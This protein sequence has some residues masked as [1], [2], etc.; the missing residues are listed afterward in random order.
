MSRTTDDGLAEEID[1][2][3]NDA[4]ARHVALAFYDYATGRDFALRGDRWFHAASTIKVP[5]LFGVFSLVDRGELPLDS[6]VHVR[7]RF[8]SVANGTSFRIERGRDGG[9]DLHDHIGK[10]MR[11]HDLARQMIVTSSNLATNLLVD[12]V[13]LE[14]LQATIERWIP[15][16]VELHRGVE[17]EAA[18]DAGISNRVTAAGLVAVLRLIQEE[19]P[20]KEASERMLE[21]L[22]AQEFRGG[23]P[24]GLPDDA[25]VANKT[26]EI[27]TVAHDVGLVYLPARE[28]YALAILT[29]WDAN[30][31]GGRR[32]VLSS[33]SRL[34]Y[35][36]LV[37]TD[38]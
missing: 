10:T 18:F 1:G 4:G 9:N 36:H 21:I 35:T 34:V 31:T 13:G 28:P 20:S 5:A 16:G 38:G 8:I 11:L 14:N 37:S 15:S 23:I 3:A 7:N 25:R 19:S 27:S 6:R 26:G 32:E 33:L 29:E 12:L 30:S 22:H 24:A 17:D 2:I